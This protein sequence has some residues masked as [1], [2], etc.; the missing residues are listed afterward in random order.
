MTRAA[1]YRGNELSELE[2]PSSVVGQAVS[3][4]PTPPHRQ[5]HLCWACSGGSTAK[6]SG[7][8]KLQAGGVQKRLKKTETT[9]WTRSLLLPRQSHRGAVWKVARGSPAGRSFVLQGGHPTR[10]PWPPHQ[11][12]R[13]G[14]GARQCYWR[15]R[16]VPGAVRP[17]QS[18]GL[19][20]QTPETYFISNDTLKGPD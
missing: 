19:R 17:I 3:A 13:K 8:R 4:P 1:Y 9:V 14:R 16:T 5:E 12:P 6:G 20:N 10:E 15:L 7:W 11:L 18:L 2:T